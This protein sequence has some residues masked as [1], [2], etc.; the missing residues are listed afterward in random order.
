M[1]QRKKSRPFFEIHDALNFHP[2]VGKFARERPAVFRGKE[3]FLILV[4]AAC[5]PVSF[6][7]YRYGKSLFESFGKIYARQPD[8]VLAFMCVV[9]K[10]LNKWDRTQSGAVIKYLCKHRLVPIDERKA[11][12]DAS[13]RRIAVIVK[14]IL[15]KKEERIPVSNL[16]EAEINGMMFP[17]CVH[18]DSLHDKELA[19]LLKAN[20]D[21]V[22][23]AR[24]LLNRIGREFE[25]WNNPEVVNY[26]K[27]GIKT[28]KYERLWEA[29]AKGKK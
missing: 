10:I 2:E 7:G 24:Q 28:A 26:M 6:S 16:S 20:T 8:D 1:P 21:S 19:T 15:N 27:T 17:K 5:D 13:G 12:Y 23:K 22:K 9:R 3:E 4:K 14:T 29:Y 11:E 18:P 25:F